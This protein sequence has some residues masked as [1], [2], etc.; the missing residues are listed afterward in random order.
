[1]IR[2]AAAALII[3]AI[4]FTGCK[5]DNG[6]DP[7]KT[8]TMT[9]AMKGEAKIELAGSGEVVIDWGDGSTPDTVTLQINI[10]YP[11]HTFS[12]ALPRTIA[13]EGENITYLDCTNLQLTALDVSKNTALKNLD[14]INN[15]LT[16][17]DVTKNTA[18]NFLECTNNRLTSLDVSKNTKLIILDCSINRLSALDVTKNTALRELYCAFNQFTAGGLNDLFGTLND[19]VADRKI[20]DIVVNPGYAGCNR[21]IATD[22]GWEVTYE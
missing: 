3:A 10:T 12:D 21:T 6:D 20:I 11:R 13:I 19:I 9:T 15:W 18:L 4:S 8:M 2:Q 14:C 22:K 7:A 5:K 16:S 17:L 1:M